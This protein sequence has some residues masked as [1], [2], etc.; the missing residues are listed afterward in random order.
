MTVRNTHRLETSHMWTCLSFE[1]QS[2]FITQKVVGSE[3]ASCLV[4]R[5]GWSLWATTAAGGHSANEICLVAIASQLDLEWRP[6][7]REFLWS[8]LL[9]PQDIRWLLYW[10]CCNWAEP[11]LRPHQSWTKA[12]GRVLLV[13]DLPHAVLRPP[14]LWA[15]ENWDFLNLGLSAKLTKRTLVWEWNLVSKKGLSVY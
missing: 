5:R 15:L 13:P 3:L 11:D 1:G 6:G 2:W 4:S 9:L 7:L 12:Q 8:P 10:G 14:R